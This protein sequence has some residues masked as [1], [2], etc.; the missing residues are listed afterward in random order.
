MQTLRGRKMYG[1]LYPGDPDR[2]F[3][4]LRLDSGVS[5]DLGFERAPV[6]GGLYGRR[7]V[8]DW[9]V[10]IPELPEIF[11]DLHADLV[12]AGLRIDPW[13][14]LIEFYRCRDALIIM[15]PVLAAPCD[16]PR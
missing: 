11:D 16:S 14:P 8:R 1:V 15:M 4:C 9:N 10:K 13:R 5:D 3:A 12:N 7:L 2:Y 6:P